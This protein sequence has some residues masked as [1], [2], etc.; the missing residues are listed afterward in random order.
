[1]QVLHSESQSTNKGESSEEGTNNRD[2]LLNMEQLTISKSHSSS[3][4]QQ[5]S[6]KADLT[7]VSKMK[8]KQL[9]SPPSPT[10]FVLGDEDLRITG[11]KKHE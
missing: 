7:K 11:E 5:N 3:E 6:M 4:Y 1:M 9:H 10:A 8:P 2:Y